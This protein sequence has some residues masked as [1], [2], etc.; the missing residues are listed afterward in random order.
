M[1]ESNVAMWCSEVHCANLVDPTHADSAQPALVEP[2]EHAYQ[3]LSLHNALCE[4]RR[5]RWRSSVMTWPWNSGQYLQQ[6]ANQR[7]H[8]MHGATYQ[9]DARLCSERTAQRVP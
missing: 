9:H 7:H 4:W 2:H 1:I 3:A 8:N 5:Y 6:Q